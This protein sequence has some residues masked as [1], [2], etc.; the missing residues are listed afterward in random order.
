MPINDYRDIAFEKGTWENLALN[1]LVNYLGK[2]RAAFESGNERDTFVVVDYGLTEDNSI[3][4]DTAIVDEDGSIGMVTTH[5]FTLDLDGL[6][7]AFRYFHISFD[8]V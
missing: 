2:E 4:V 5:E 7:D 1:K 3:S 6:E 8:D